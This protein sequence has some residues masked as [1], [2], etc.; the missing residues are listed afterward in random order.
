[1][2]NVKRTA[3]IVGC[4]NNGNRL[5]RFAETHSKSIVNNK[6]LAIAMRLPK[7]ETLLK[8]T[9]AVAVCSIGGI[10]YVS[11]S[12]LNRIAESDYVK[13]AFKLVRSHRGECKFV[14]LSREMCNF[15]LIH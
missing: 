7:M 6:R 2:E 12:Q 5:G 4:C 10:S 3:I 13:E 8:A 1:M 14:A 9:L 15:A 11:M